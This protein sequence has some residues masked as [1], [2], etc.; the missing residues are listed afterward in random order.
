LY[1]V[2]RGGETVTNSR[3]A[4]LVALAFLWTFCR[5]ADAQEAHTSSTSTEPQVLSLNFTNNGQRLD[6]TVGQQ[7]EITLGTVGPK[8]YGTPQVSSPAIQLESIALAGPPN[9]GGSTYIYIFEATAEGEAQIKIPI[10]H[11]ENP[12]STKRLTFSLTIHVESPPGNPPAPHASMTPDQANTAPWKNAWTNLL[13]DVRQTFT[14]SLPRLTGV[15]VE[16]V[17]ANPGPSD[18]ELTMYLGNAEGEVLAV[19]SKTVPV[20]DCRHVLFVFPKGGLQVS[21]GQVYSI[22]LS[23]GSVFG[24]KY[25]VGGYSNGAEFFN[26]RPLLSNTRSTFLFRTFGV[27]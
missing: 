2:L 8:Q 11:S 7:I 10:I 24:W 5:N 17:V 6:S 26:G 13:N 20:A 25:V 19:V 16:L 14:P 12:D 1:V 23:G 4:F 22:R 27:S 3:S 15:E 18:D 9:P 21:P